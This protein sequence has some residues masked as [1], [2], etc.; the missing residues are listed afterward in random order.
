MTHLHVPV[1]VLLA[2]VRSRTTNPYGRSA[3][4]Q[5]E[6]V[7]YVDEI[8]PLIRRTATQGLDGSVR[9]V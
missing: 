9:D 8:E 4:D 6:I 7:T 1:E 3:E 5:A 2:R